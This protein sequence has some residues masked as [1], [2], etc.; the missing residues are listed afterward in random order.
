MICHLHNHPT[1]TTT[2][3]LRVGLGKKKK[4]KKTLDWKPLRF[5][6][7][8]NIINMIFVDEGNYKGVQKSGIHPGGWVLII[9]P[10]RNATNTAGALLGGSFACVCGCVWCVRTVLPCLLPGLVFFPLLLLL[11]LLH[12]RLSRESA[13][14]CSSSSSIVQA[15]FDN[16]KSTS[17]SIDNWSCCGK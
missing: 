14:T 9:L 10:R 4:K 11:L 7:L 8:Q 1:C 5:P 12:L 17:D 2:Q 15:G 16:C 3:K 13:G 6:Q